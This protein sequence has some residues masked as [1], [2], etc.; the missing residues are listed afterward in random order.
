M[1]K[2][3]VLTAII[4]AG[5]AGLTCAKILHHAGFQALV[6]DYKVPWEK[7]CAGILP[8][9]VYTHY[10]EMD[11]YSYNYTHFKSIR[12]V[13][14]R[15]EY[16]TVNFQKDFMV[17]SRKDLSHYLI[18]SLNISGL[19]IIK[20]KVID[21]SHTGASWLINTESGQYQ[22]DIIVG[23]DGVNSIVR[24]ATA[25]R[26]SREDLAISV[27]YYLEPIEEHTCIMKS[28]DII[29]YEWLIYSRG[30]ASA[31]IMAQWGTIVAKD[32][33]ER[34]NN[35]LYNHLPEAKIIRKYSALIPSAMGPSFFEKPCAGKDWILVG[36][37]AG[38]VDP[39]MGEGIYYAMKSGEL[40]AKAIISGKPKKYDKLWFK[41]YGKSLMALAKKKQ[42]MLQLAN[43]L[44]ALAYGVFI[45]THNV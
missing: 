7:P 45:Y 10:L 42:G 9:D 16:D 3:K 32:L 15:E 20:E 11:S 30:H 8:P 2:V 28:L 26:F 5:P 37:A 40:A 43:E 33:F 35:F 39:I 36:D 38:H 44:G 6:F 1:K 18:S 17:V 29:G 4:G 34:L 22:A 25:G 24:K 23:A 31:G 12:W 27:G 13:S 41:A 19:D 21:I 14:P